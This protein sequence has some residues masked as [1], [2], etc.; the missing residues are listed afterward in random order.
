MYIYINYIYTYITYIYTF[1][2]Y[3]FTKLHV[4]KKLIHRVK[5]S[6][7]VGFDLSDA[8]DHEGRLPQGHQQSIRGNVWGMFIYH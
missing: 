6:S 2:T 1:I 8:D 5:S 3:R 4:E 7:Y